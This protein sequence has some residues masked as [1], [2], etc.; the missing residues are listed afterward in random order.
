LNLGLG[1]TLSKLKSVYPDIYQ[2]WLKNNTDV[3]SLIDATVRY[4]FRPEESNFNN[5]LID[6]R[7]FFF[8]RSFIQEA[9]KTSQPLSLITTWIQNVDEQRH[10][11]DECVSMPFNLNNVD[12]TV[13]A[14]SIYGITSGAL[15]NINGF[16][17][18]FIRSSDIQQVYLNTT[19]FISWAIKANFSSRP[20]LAQVYYPSTYN[21]LWYASRTLFL[22]ETETQNY[23]YLM[24]QNNL[25]NN[26]EN[27]EKIAFIRQFRALKP[28]FE[29]AKSYL[30]DAFETTTT[31]NLLNW[32]RN[33]SNPNEMYFCDF[34]GMNDTDILGKHHESKDDCVFSTAQ[35]INILIATWT[36]QDPQSKSLIFKSNTPIEAKDLIE[37]SVNWLTSNIFN[38]KY[39]KLNAFFSG[40]VKGFSSLPFWYPGSFLQYLNGTFVEEANVPMSDLESIIDGVIGSIDENTYQ[41]LLAKTH[42]GVSTPLDFPGYNTKG[43]FF[44]FWSSEPYTYAVSLLALTQ[45]NNIVN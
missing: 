4:A 34:L 27:A 18:A 24:K 17:D 23:M 33:D 19:K 25:I 32:K 36:Y 12:V 14:N 40:S 11:K 44:P 37:Q 10:L 9:Y 45:H 13:G 26:A 22:L 1:A 3:E 41:E 21:F 42:F 35:A 43:N 7:T 39:K 38:R 31:L 6:P 29:E 20:D 8:A 30:L 2:A 5:N 15:F 28:I 16:G